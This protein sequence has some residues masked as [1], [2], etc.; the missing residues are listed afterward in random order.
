MNSVDIERQCLEDIRNRISGLCVRLIGRDP[1]EA[2][3]DVLTDKFLFVVKRDR[4]RLLDSGIFV[5]KQEL[6]PLINQ[7]DRA[8]EDDADSVVTAWQKLKERLEVTQNK[9]DEHIDQLLQISSPIL[10][11]LQEELDARDYA[12]QKRM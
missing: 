7:M 1:D 4:K 6:I 10:T 2:D 3:M 8:I 12:E 5:S 11:R 9:N